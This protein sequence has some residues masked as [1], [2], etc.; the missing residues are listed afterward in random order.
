MDV[1]TAAAERLPLL[2]P[3][4]GSPKKRT[5]P[6]YQLQ[7]PTYIAALTCV[8]IFIWMLSSTLAALPAMRLTEDVYCRRYYNRDEEIDERLCKVEKVQSQVAYIFGW[9]E[10]LNGVFGLTVALP[11]G[12]MADYTRKPVYILGTVGHSLA[13]LWTIF[14]I[15]QWR[16]VPIEWILAGPIF[17]SLGGGLLVATSLLQAMLLDVVTPENRAKWFFFFSLSSQ[18]AGFLGMPISAK[19]SEVWSPWAPLA[20]VAGLGPVNILL[21]VFMPETTIF[22]GADHGEEPTVEVGKSSWWSMAMSHC[23]QT[24]RDV[25][26]SLAMLRNG[27]A[28]MLLLCVLTIIPVNVSLGGILLQYVSQRFKWS[29]ADAGYIMAL[30]GGFVILSMGFIL[31]SISTFLTTPR[32]R[33][34]MSVHK[35][36]LFLARS[37]ATALLV[38]MLFLSGPAIGYVIVGLVITAL[39]SGLAPLCRSLI[40]DYVNPTQTSS[41]FTS[42]GMIETLG[43]MPTAPLLAGAFSAGLQLRGFFYSLPYEV[44]AIFAMISVIALFLLKP[45][46]RNSES[47]EPTSHEGETEDE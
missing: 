23:K 24:F 22:A 17:Q 29:L 8:A 11:F 32:R 16:I 46:Q 31:P 34:R 15:H 18:T 2:D 13:L 10:T 1:P 5:I 25:K 4:S 44:S 26:K 21:M 14:V 39:G 9:S 7:R 19:L 47:T 40:L 41:L 35:K 45:A 33:A 3:R 20:I 30:R 6:F 27:S 36:D 28:A 37:S 38:G 42:I 12:A 43:A